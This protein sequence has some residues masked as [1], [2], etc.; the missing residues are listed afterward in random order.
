MVN[1]GRT[2]RLYPAG[3]GEDR[4][5]YYQLLK[6]VP[7]SIDTDFLRE[8]PYRTVTH[9]HPVAAVRICLNPQ[10][11]GGHEHG[12]VRPVAFLCIT[13]TSQLG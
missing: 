13:S 2:A 1:D 4:A 12:F 8:R 7:N 10:T 11:G 5:E 6:F 3:R 9:C